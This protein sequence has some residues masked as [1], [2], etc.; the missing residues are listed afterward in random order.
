MICCFNAASLVVERSAVMEE[1]ARLDY[2]Q[3]LGIAFCPEK[4]IVD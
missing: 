3:D 1:G 4:E 2:C